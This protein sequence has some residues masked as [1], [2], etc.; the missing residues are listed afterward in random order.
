MHVCLKEKSG[1]PA[2]GDVVVV[3]LLKLEA[4][5]DECVWVQRRV[6]LIR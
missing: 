2:N 1:Q 3:G 5:M 4:M 6:G